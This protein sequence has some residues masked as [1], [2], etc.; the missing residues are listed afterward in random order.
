MKRLLWI[1]G[2]IVILYILVASFNFVVN[3]TEYVVLTQFGRPIRTIDKPG[4]KFKFPQPINKV[5]RFDR[6]LQLFESRF[7]EFLTKDKKNVV[8]KFFVGLWSG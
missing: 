3:E 5:N 6:R 8:L 7:V 2:A 4:L 1:I